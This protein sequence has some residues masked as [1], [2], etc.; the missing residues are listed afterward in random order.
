MRVAIVILNWNGKKFLEKFLPSVI[1]TSSHIARVIVADNASTDGSVTY[2][3]QSFPEVEII[4]NSKNGGFATGYNTALQKVDSEYYILLNS[5]ID[6]T[7]GWIEPVIAL[8]DSNKNIA[9]V[10]PKIRSY[11]Q[12]EK[13]EY[14]GAAGGYIDA[15]GYPFCRGR[16]FQNI[17]VDHGQYDDIAEV[18]WATGACMFIRKDDFWLAGGFDDDFFAHMEEID[19]CW[20]LKNM[21]KKIMVCPQSVV[22]HIG[23]GTLPK[24][25]WKKTYLNMRNNNIML[26]KNLPKRKLIPIFASR[27]LLDAIASFKFLLDGGFQDLWAV[28]RAHS[29]FWGTIGTT[30]HKR[31]KTNRLPVN[32]VYKGNIVFDYFILGI[33]TFNQ[34]KPGR[35]SNNP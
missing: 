30:L 9:A 5:D 14:A 4:I 27:F 15:F 13:F 28:V 32:H 18:F 23:G 12:P 11:Y 19:L 16:L 35:F 6:V 24:K 20:R 8:L 1:E 22:F 33:R 3:K 7:P 21:G 10:Q 25:S 17:E 34:L 26:L 29:S 31:W 2:L